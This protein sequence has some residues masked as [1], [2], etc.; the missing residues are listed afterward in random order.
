MFFHY[1]VQTRRYYISRIAG[2]VPANSRSWVTDLLIVA[3][4]VVWTV[5]GCYYAGEFISRLANF[6]VLVG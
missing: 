2:C 1:V 3:P 6:H 5:V 4:Q